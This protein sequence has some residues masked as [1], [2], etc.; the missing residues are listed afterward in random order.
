VTGETACFPGEGYFGWFI[1]L[2]RDDG[3]G[4]LRLLGQVSRSKLG[5][6]YGIRVQVMA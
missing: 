4:S 1:S 5:G 2:Y 3:V 6:A